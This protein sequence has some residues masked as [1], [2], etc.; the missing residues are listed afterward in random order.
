MKPLEIISAE[1]HIGEELSPFQLILKEWF[2]TSYMMGSSIFF[3][4]QLLLYLLVQSR[5]SK[6]TQEFFQFVEEPFCDL[7]LDSSI[8]MEGDGDGNSHA[9]GSANPS[10]EDEDENSS[11]WESLH[12]HASNPP[13]IIT[14]QNDGT[15]STNDA[16]VDEHRAQSSPQAVENAEVQ[17][18]TSSGNQGSE[19]SAERRQD[20]Y[21]NHQ[22]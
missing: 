19:A 6:T 17:E 12:S 16:G 20:D 14:E 22:I 11:Q 21:N 4:I 2:F 18:N 7:D 8:P 13:T 5:R 10:Q 15:S 3:L 9:N 1:V